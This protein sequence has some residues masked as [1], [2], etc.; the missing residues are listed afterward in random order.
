MR[1]CLDCPTPLEG[2]PPQR[3]HCVPCAYAKRLA[4]SAAYAEDIRLGKRNV[5][6]HEVRATDR[7]A[8]SMKT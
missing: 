1:V 2:T 4:A 3:K 8:S 6:T 7:C 5:A